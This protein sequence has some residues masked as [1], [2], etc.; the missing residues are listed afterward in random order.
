MSAHIA[1]ASSNDEV[2]DCLAS[3]RQDAERSLAAVYH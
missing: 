3:F 1:R 2:R